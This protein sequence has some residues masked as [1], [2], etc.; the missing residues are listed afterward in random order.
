MSAFD[1]YLRVS[2]GSTIETY[3]HAMDVSLDPT[4][5]MLCTHVQLCR[6]PLMQP[7]QRAMV[8]TVLAGT[9]P[10]YNRLMRPTTV[11]ANSQIYLW[12]KPFRFDYARSDWFRLTARQ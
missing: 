5:L 10:N 6:Q 8:P 12:K 11:V 2:F 1:E 4:T 9:P 3:S 7:Q